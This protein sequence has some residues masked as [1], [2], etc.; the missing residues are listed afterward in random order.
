[1]NE[2]KLWSSEFVSMGLTNFVIFISHYSLIASMPVIVMDHLGGSELDTGLA[3]TFFQIGTVGFRPLAGMCIDSINKR[4]LMLTATGIFLLTMLGYSLVHSLTEL[5]GLRV[6][7][8]LIFSL[9]TTAAAALAAMVLPTFCKARG[10]GYFALTT[11]LAMV[12]GPTLGL[13]IVGS[14]GMDGMM[15]FLGILGV[16]AFVLGNCKRLPENIVRPV[17]RPHKGLKISDFIEKRALGP[18]MFGSLVFFAYGGVLMLISI[19]T[20]SMGLQSETSLFFAVFA[21]VIVVT[22]PFVG[23]VFDKWGM[24]AGIYPGFVLFAIGMAL[25]GMINDLTGLLLA[26]VF[27][28]SGFGILSPA[29]QTMAVQSAPLERSGV[30]TATYFWSLDI[31]VGLAA[32]LLSVLAGYIG[33]AAMYGVFSTAV[34]ILTGI[35]YL[36]W[37]HDNSQK[38]KRLFRRRIKKAAK[39]IVDPRRYS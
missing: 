4:K 37:Q 6:I 11:N 10:I 22:R 33:Y 26:A 1:M 18:S 25:L 16:L 17:E 29:F 9:A 38:Y 14:L 27:L 5:Y 36:L 28:G 19:Y 15:V 12:I 24:N 13:L 7:H 31:S 20:K 39:K 23:Q 3:M 2:G 34:V 32:S 30:A 35:M 21:A 8:G